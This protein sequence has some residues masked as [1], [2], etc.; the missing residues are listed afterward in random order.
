VAFVA[1]IVH[2]RQGRNVHL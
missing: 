2:Y 1:L